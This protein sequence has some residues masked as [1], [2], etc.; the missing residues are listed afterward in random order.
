MSFLPKYDR[1][2]TRNMSKL[3]QALPMSELIDDLVSEG[4]AS[5]EQGRKLRQCETEQERARVLLY[6]VL[7][8]KGDDVVEPFCKVLKAAGHAR[9]V[10]DVM[11]R[12]VVSTDQVDQPAQQQQPIQQSQ[13]NQQVHLCERR[14]YVI[15]YLSVCVPS[16][17]LQVF[18]FL[19][20]ERFH[21]Q[22]TQI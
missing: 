6:H 8:Y 1:Y 18:Y 11:G 7:P 2:I 12:G 17:A 15:M 5:L 9:I 21:T 16:R 19:N 10:T 20:C 13:S 3:V 14:T 22:G 4:L